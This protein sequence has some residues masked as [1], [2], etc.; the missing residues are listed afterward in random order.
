MSQSHLEVTD[1]GARFYGN[2][3]IDTLGGAGFAS[4]RTVSD[5]ALD[6][7]QYDGIQLVVSKS[8]G[9]SNAVF[10]DGHCLPAAGLRS[11]PAKG[12]TFI[13]KDEKLPKNGGREQA[14]TSWEHDFTVSQDLPKEV[15][16]QI[17]WSDLKPTYRGKEDKKAGPLQLDNIRQVS[18]MN[19]R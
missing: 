16:I 13:L 8:D 12:Y 11:R 10:F 17:M 3:D 4:Q 9:K 5:V 7:S 2:L 15:M 19:R 14:T 1:Q 6:L 18:L